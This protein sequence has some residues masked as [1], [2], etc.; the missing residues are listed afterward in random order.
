PHAIA[1]AADLPCDT[2]TL[3]G[4]Q[5][6]LSAHMTIQGPGADVLSVSGGGESR[7]LLVNEGVT[8]TISGL[9][10]TGGDADDFDVADDGGGV[11]NAGTLTIEN[12]TISGN[13][14]TVRGGGVLNGHTLTIENSTISGNS[15]D[16]GGGVYNG[17][18]LTI[19]NSTISGNSADIIGGGIWSPAHGRG[20]IVNSTI[21]GNSADIIGGGLSID[22]GFTLSGTLLAGN[23]GGN[24]VGGSFESSSY[25][26]S[27]DDSCNLTGAGDLDDNPNAN[28]DPVLADNGGPTWTHA[29]LPGSAAID[30]IPDGVAGCGTD[31]QTD[32]RGVSRPRG[33]G[34]DIGAYEVEF[35]QTYYQACLYAGSL[36]QVSLSMSPNPTVSCGRGEPVVLR[37]GDNLQN[38]T[39]HACLFGGSLSQVGYSEP[40]SCGRG[41]PIA[42][43]AG[44][45]LY[46]CLYAGRLSQVG[47]SQPGSCGRGAPVGFGFV[48]FG[49]EE[50]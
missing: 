2:I 16:D 29:L 12:S 34:C 41:E 38:D 6:E 37:S 10:I 44:D 24:C 17:H 40:S 32:Q 28:L 11:Y 49:Q 33:S 20:S 27:D 18:M 4:A 42:L 5:L 46:A 13:I 25:N 14:A 39:L 35:I 50:T 47:T 22:R 21:S 8:V 7:V 31:I 48:T 19:E 23:T 36:S 9:T 26:L 43:V 3:A 30:H 1:F 45:D 15:A